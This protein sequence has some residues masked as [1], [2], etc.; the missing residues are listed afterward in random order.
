MQHKSDGCTCRSAIRSYYAITRKTTRSET[1]LL[2]TFVCQY[3]WSNSRYD[4]MCI[5]QAP[6]W[7]RKQTCSSVIDAVRSLWWNDSTLVQFLRDNFVLPDTS[8]SVSP[9][10]TGTHNTILVPLPSFCKIHKLNST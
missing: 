3:I 4:D 8:S 9:C 2:R 1:A 6:S 5:V 10:M 7:H